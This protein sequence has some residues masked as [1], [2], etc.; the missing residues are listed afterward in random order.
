ML[1][2][3]LNRHGKF[4][5]ALAEL[6]IAAR[7]DPACGTVRRYLG[8]A[9]RGQGKLEDALA[10]YREAIRLRPD[11]CTALYYVDTL[12]TDLGKVDVL[13]AEYREMIRLRPNW[14]AAL[15]GLAWKLVLARDRPVGDHDEA[16]VHARKC[17]ALTPNDATAVNTLA[18]AE[19]RV[20]HW[21]ESIAA[22]RRSI[23]LRNGGSAYDSF[24]LAMAHAQKGEKDEARKWFD[25]A[26]AWTKEKTQ[27][28]PSCSGFGR[29]PPSGS[30]NQGRPRLAQIRYQRTRSEWGL[31]TVPG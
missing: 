28:T 19:Y 15:N 22:A 4:E 12:L 2:D 3:I 17:V 26:A 21:D 30:V 25:K 29:K 14:D 23:T 1:G 10:E 16:L 7:I 18:L 6:Q 8:D 9:L 27:R 11:D 20:H 5:A 24:F 31:A 13:I